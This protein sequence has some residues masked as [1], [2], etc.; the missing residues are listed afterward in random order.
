MAS[1][2]N[3][4]YSKSHEKSWVTHPIAFPSMA[5]ARFNWNMMFGRELGENALPRQFYIIPEGSILISGEMTRKACPSCI[6]KS[7]RFPFGERL[8]HSPLNRM[9]SVLRNVLRLRGD[10]ESVQKQ[11]VKYKIICLSVAYGKELEISFNP[12]DKILSYSY[13]NC[14]G[15]AQIA[16]T[17]CSDRI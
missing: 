17:V 13:P 14:V 16:P 2:G 11:C 12:R 1:L 7:L 8:R 10:S 3:S 9:G 5:K 4:K 15:W 6:V